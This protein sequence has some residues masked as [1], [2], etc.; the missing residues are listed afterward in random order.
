[1]RRVTWKKNVTDL[2]GVTPKEHIAELG[3]ELPPVPQ[4]VADQG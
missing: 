4:A 1:M 2:A 3:L